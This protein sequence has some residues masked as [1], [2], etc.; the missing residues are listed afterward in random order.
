[1]DVIWSGLKGHN[2]SAQGNA[3]GSLYF[4]IQPCKGVTLNQ[5]CC[6]KKTSMSRPYRAKIIGCIKT[7]GV[8]LG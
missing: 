3:L 2:I 5:N 7:Q 8:A 1:M 6:T 4:L